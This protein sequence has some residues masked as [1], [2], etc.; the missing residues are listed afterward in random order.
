M[1]AA[2]VFEGAEN[3]CAATVLLHMVGQ[4]LPGDVGGATLVWALN[5]KPRAMEL[6]VLLG[7]KQ[8][9]VVI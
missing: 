1:F 4:I 6:M 2:G 7:R 5:R 9:H 3:K 8:N